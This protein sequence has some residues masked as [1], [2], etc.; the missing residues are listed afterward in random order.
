MIFTGER[1]KEIRKELKL[2]QKQFS[3]RIGISYGHLS[4]I[5]NNKDYPSSTIIRLISVEFHVNEEWIKT[6]QGDKYSPYGKSKDDDIQFYN[7]LIPDV[8][9]KLIELLP[10]NENALSSV[11][12]CISCINEI[13]DS[14]ITQSKKSVIFEILSYYLCQFTSI[15]LNAHELNDFDEL[16]YHQLILEMITELK[17]RIEL[18]KNV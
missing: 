7:D 14:S 3:A 8:A 15:I 17:E 6:G 4:N 5:E 1:I 2:T 11:C 10:H 18:F 9:K 13:L 12:I 16:K